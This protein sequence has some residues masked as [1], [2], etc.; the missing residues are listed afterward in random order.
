[1]DEGTIGMHLGLRAVLSVLALVLYPPL[2]RRMGTA[3]LYKAAMSLLP[4][5]VLAFPILNFL[6]LN[7]MIN[8]PLFYVIL[9]SMFTLW[10]VAG[11][12]YSKSVC[13]TPC[14]R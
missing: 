7:G 9:V 13:T 2:Q 6:A 1:M 14:D 11:L 3:R 10:S 4:F 12:T 8:S 5:V